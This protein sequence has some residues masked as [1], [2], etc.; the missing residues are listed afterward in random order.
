VF[1]GAIDVIELVVSVS[2]ERLKCELRK[3]LTGAIFEAVSNY[4]PKLPCLLPLKGDAHFL[5]ARFVQIHL[6]RH[7]PYKI[8]VLGAL[9]MLPVSIP[10][11]LSVSR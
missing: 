9:L 6:R 10:A 2:G 11:K 8:G 3:I 5:G 4:T 7:T 1:D